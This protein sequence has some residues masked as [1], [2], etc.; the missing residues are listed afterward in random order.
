MNNKEKGVFKFPDNIE[1]LEETP[2]DEL[3]QIGIDSLGTIT[4]A[5]YASLGD[6]IEVARALTEQIANTLREQEEYK[7]NPPT[8]GLDLKNLPDHTFINRS[9]VSDDYFQDKYALDTRSKV[10]GIGSIVTISRNMEEGFIMSKPVSLIGKEVLRAVSTLTLKGHHKVTASTIYREMTCNKKAKIT[11]RWE[12]VIEEELRHGITTE[13]LIKKGDELEDRGLTP[14]RPLYGTIYSFTAEPEIV[15]GK[16]TLVYSFNDVPIFTKYA[17]LHNHIKWKPKSV[18]N[19]PISYTE[20][21]AILTTWLYDQIL[22]M[23]DEKNPR[24]TTIRFSTLYEETKYWE[25]KKKSRREENRLRELI[26]RSLD[27][28]IAEKEIKGYAFKTGAGKDSKVIYGQR[29]R[30]QRNGTRGPTKE[31]L[32]PLGEKPTGGTIEYSS[33]EV[34]L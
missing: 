4:E 23:Y 30:N 6:N 5:I 2:I 13:V 7:I 18:L 24:G 21:N 19:T 28:W 22:W 17:I 15:N 8:K 26:E 25:Y 33:I 29:I 12:G 32:H 9:K 14:G 1:D 3:I 20:A 34:Y 27:H 16:D 10:K 11:P 31:V